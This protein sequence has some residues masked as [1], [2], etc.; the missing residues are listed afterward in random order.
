MFS[1]DEIMTTELVTL[2][3]TATVGQAIFIMT[4]HHIRHLP[5][6]NSKGEIKGLVSH[7]DLLIARDKLETPLSEV[8]TSKVTTIDRHARIRA[9]ASYLVDH[10][11]GCLPVTDDGKLVGIVTDSDFIGVAV[12]LIEQLEATEPEE[13]Y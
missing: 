6:V 3:D 13:A 1:I 8:M 10:K 11:I 7:R 2:S 5:L 12:N 4:D 9:A